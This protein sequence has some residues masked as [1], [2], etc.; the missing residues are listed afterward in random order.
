[1][2]NIYLPHGHADLKSTCPPLNP[3]SLHYVFIAFISIF[4]H[5]HRACKFEIHMPISKI[6]MPWTFGKPS[7]RTLQLWQ[8]RCSWSGIRLIWWHFNRLN[9]TV[10]QI[11]QY[12]QCWWHQMKI[13]STA[14]TFDKLHTLLDCS[15]YVG[16]W[17][18]AW[19]EVGEGGCRRKKFMKIIKAMRFLCWSWCFTKH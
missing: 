16:A 11:C 18:D 19:S 12:P 3:T 9:T 2:K 14:V 6:Y 10:P 4:L 5:A 7:L 1:M 13:S 17:Y 8:K 15:A